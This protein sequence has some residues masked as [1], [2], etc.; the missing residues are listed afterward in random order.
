MT[1]GDIAS[2]TTDSTTSNEAST[3]TPV[4]AVL[5]PSDVGPAAQHE[6]VERHGNGDHHGHGADASPGADVATAEPTWRRRVGR[7]ALVYLFSRLCVMLGAAIVAAELGADRL[8]QEAD[9]PERAV[10]RSALRRR[11]PEERAAPDPRRAHVV[12]RRL[13]P[14]DRPARLPAT[15]AA[16]RHVQRRR[17][18]RRVL[19]RLPDA[20]ARASTRCCPAATCSPRSLVNLVLGFVAILLVGLLAR[21]LYGAAV[22]EKAMVLMALFPGSFVLS[23]AYSEALLLVLAAACLL[24]LLEKRWWWAGVF[25]ALATATR[26]NGLAL[27]LACAVAAFLAIRDDA[28]GGRS[29]H[30]CS[31]PLGWIAFQVWLGIHAHETGV[32]FRVQREAWN[33]GTSFGFTAINRSVEGRSPTRSARRPT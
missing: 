12:G 1:T 4:A 26:P 28:T 20:R 18:P 15:R 29:P 9:F 13:V 3:A 2:T 7:S 21:R 16:E 11:D 19:P 24:C 32:W 8:K 17:R 10:R 22:A 27:C 25:A 6:R 14:E 30:R 5:D 23:F 33:E 31:S